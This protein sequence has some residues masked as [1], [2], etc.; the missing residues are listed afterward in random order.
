[1][2]IFNRSNTT[3]DPYEGLQ[4]GDKVKD[5]LTK[6]TGIIIAR[7]EHLTGCNQVYL[8]PTSD[9]GNDL[10]TGEWFD[11]ERIES[12]EKNVVTSASRFGGCD[13]PPPDRVT[14]RG[15]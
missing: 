11:V 14:S 7:S 4:M 13:I 15:R 10:K 3:N 6:F 1:M 9:K 5:T 12:V 2:K 8:L